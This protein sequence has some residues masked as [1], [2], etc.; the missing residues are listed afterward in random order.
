MLVHVS[1]IVLNGFPRRLQIRS[2]CNPVPWPFRLAVIILLSLQSRPH[3]PST[4]PPPRLSTCAPDLRPAPP[5]SLLREMVRSNKQIPKIEIHMRVCG[6]YE[7]D[8][9]GIYDK[10]NDSLNIQYIYSVSITSCAYG[11]SQNKAQNISNNLNPSPHHQS[12]SSTTQS[13]VSSYARGHIHPSPSP[14]LS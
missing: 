7:K 8:K 4:Y 5:P 12:V 14:Y 2:L 13:G 1:N 6:L 3:H 11:G 10:S 9:V